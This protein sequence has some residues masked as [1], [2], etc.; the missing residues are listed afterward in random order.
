MSTPQQKRD[1]SKDLA[2]IGTTIAG[3]YKVLNVLGQGGFGSV[4]LVEIVAG[5]VGEKLA[6]KLIPPELS[7]DPK[8]KDQFLNEIRVAMRMVNKYVVQIR[9]VGETDGGQLY[10]TMD[11]CPG[12]TLAA[13]IKREGKLDPTRAISIALRILEALKTAHAAGV[14]H[15]DLKPA[16]VMVL[17]QDTY[18]TVRVLDFGIAT[19][20]NSGRTGESG[21]VGS[22]HYMPPEQF[23]N[24]ELGFYTDTYAVGV[25]LYECLTGEKPYK[26]ST[27]QEVYNDLKSRPVVPPAEL[28]PDLSAQPGL[29]DLIARALERNPDLR[30][31]TAKDMFGELKAVLDGKY[32]PP[33]KA[34][35]AAAIRRRPASIAPRRTSSF[36]PGLAIGAGIAVLGI[37]AFIFA[38]SSKP[39]ANPQP[40]QPT[41]TVVIKEEPTAPPPE[42]PPAIASQPR[43]IPFETKSTAP[44]SKPDP[45]A[46]KREA[47]AKASQLVAEAAKLA[48]TGNAWDKVR[49]ACFDAIGL[50]ASTPELF[51]LKGL[52]ELKLGMHSEAVDSLETA[53]MRIPAEKQDASFLV[54]CIEA[55]RGTSSLDP[56]VLRA[57]LIQA[58]D[59]LR[60]EPKN[61]EAAAALIPL[62]EEQ[63]GEAELVEIVERA[64]S[65]KIEH[66]EI[67]RAHQK[68]VVELPKQRAAQAQ[69]A[70]TAA[71]KAFEARDYKL[72]ASKAEEGLRGHPLA[73]LG[74]LHA[75][76]LLEA[77]KEKDAL[78]SLAKNARFVT[79]AEDI[80]RVGILYS[81]ANIGLYTK[82]GEKGPE[83]MERA[84]ENLAAAIEV[85]KLSKA[86]APQLVA[87]VYTYRARLAALQSSLAR[88]DEEVKAAKEEDRFP[89]HIFH[90]AESYFILGERITEPD[91]SA[92]YQRAISRL[93]WYNE[94][95]EVQKDSNASFLRA[96]CYLRMGGKRDNFSKAD[97]NF[98]QAERFGMKDPGLYAAWAEAQAGLGDLL[99]SAQKYR[100]A[101][102]I[103]PTEDR[104]LKAAQ[105]FIEANQR[106]AAAGVL[107]KGQQQFPRSTRIR[108]LLAQ[109]S[110]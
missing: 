106:I 32:A 99:K 62:L 30:F 69:D 34:A 29:S 75:E 57:L 53:R 3:K 90:Q 89:P 33:Q 8:I 85:L 37:L 35:P 4:F 77:G 68:Y 40:V 13:V 9:D 96:L 56:R 45:Q 91:K 66:P 81:R 83:L 52:A 21:F 63:G 1:K 46:A 5:M 54:L 42:P 28:N 11:Y 58:C 88:V 84:A 72:A 24:G 14:V 60:G 19:A 97:T 10:Y 23:I 55:R 105:T 86:K 87:A 98:A 22:P 104:C 107:E 65:E 17:T 71:R 16:N 18:E 47:D 51:R 102:E 82:G 26:G 50:G 74:L 73:D 109:V 103:S 27:A 41:P 78:A 25:I 6:L 76:A 110:R 43:V 93:G 70:A 36:V 101:Y 100:T 94:F 64:K 67:D 38:N 80:A 12:D 31:P 61:V 92:A 15:R 39:E 49:E 108:Q 79:E 59:A 44:P 2:V 95:K 20:L 7:G 48:Q